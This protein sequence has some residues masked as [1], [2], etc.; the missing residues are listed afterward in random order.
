MSDAGTASYDDL[1][2]LHREWRAF[3]HPAMR[4]GVPDYGPDA[5]RDRL[6]RLP[7]WRRRLDAIDTTGWPTAEADDALLMGAELAG[8]GFLL[9]VLR[10]WARDPGFYATV[11]GEQSDV[12]AH[13]GQSAEPSVDLFAVRWPLSPE[14]DAALAAQLG[15]VPRLLEAARENLAGSDARD[16]WTHGAQTFLDQAEVLRALGAGT[17]VMRT[18]EGHVP[19]HL[20]APSDG[21]AAAIA[22]AEA[23]TR[24][25]AAWITEEAEHRHGPSGVGKEAY[26]RWSRDVALSPY[27]WDAQVTLLQRELDRAVA[28]LRLEE[29]RNA[30]LPA[31]PS[32]EDPEAY[33]RFAEQRTATFLAFLVRHGFLP[34]EEPYRAAMVAQ[35]SDYVPP[36]ER[37][38]FAHGTALD[39]LPLLSHAT[40]WIELTRLL[41][42]PHPSPIRRAEPVFNLFADRSEGWATALEEVFLHLGLYDDSPRVREIVWIQ[43]ANRAAR[44]LAS[45]R[46]QANEIGLDEAGRFHASWTP[47]GWS[48]A[49]DPLVGFE[50]LLYLR[51]PGYG[52]SYILGKVQLDALLALRSHRADERGT[53]FD[54]AATW[55]DV[56][57][58][59]IV[60]PSLLLR[61][62]E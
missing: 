51:Q 30:D 32:I 59:G 14:D 39:P 10:P 5:M 46:V 38:F 21:L 31:L 55:A 48:D 23:A 1:V 15:R 24:G 20:P 54:L 12:P 44:G 16:L 60:P 29:A 50:Q 19:A 43:L 11:F 57:A 26:D 8:Y 56:V 58:G 35:T 4:D 47:R 52:T 7:G 6:E 37:D 3:L 45:L 18:L 17:L 13:E 27:D 61:E 9:E 53:P 41:R 28:S 62:L 34:D 42:E 22:D 40:H 33:R 25:F 36:A 2:A 49:A